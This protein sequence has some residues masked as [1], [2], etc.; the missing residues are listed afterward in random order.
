MHHSADLLHRQWNHTEADLFIRNN[1]T[2]AKMAHCGET[3]QN[4][5][6]AHP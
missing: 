3:A 6:Q 4:A 2:P 1:K 5:L